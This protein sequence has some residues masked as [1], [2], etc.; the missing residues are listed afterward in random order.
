[1]II[2][3]ETFCTKDIKETFYWMM[4]CSCVY[5]LF[6]PQR[7]KLFHQPHNLLLQRQKFCRRHQ[8]F[9]PDDREM[10]SLAFLI[11]TARHRG[12]CR[13]HFFFQIGVTCLFIAA[14]I[15][16]IYPPRLCE[17]AYVTDGACSEEEI[18]EMELVVLKGLNWG[19]S[20]MTPNSWVK[21]YLQA[22]QAALIVDSCG[23]PPKE[24]ML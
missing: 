11:L 22:N 16:E 4:Q 12:P 17:F 20:P 8:S 10:L 21:L 14:K 1:M 24:S 2:Y 7:I 15:E 13:C 23:E 6:R 3:K 5:V 9:F 18:V 19:L